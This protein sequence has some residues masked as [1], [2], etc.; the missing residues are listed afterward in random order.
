MGEGRRGGC[1]REE[2][3]GLLAGRWRIRWPVALAADQAADGAGRRAMR[4]GRE[5]GSPT[6]EEADAVAGAGGGGHTTREQERGDHQG[7]VGRGS[8]A[9]DTLW[10]GALARKEM[11]LP[12]GVAPTAVVARR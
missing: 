7:D 4:T 8:R 6:G 9:G 2:G 3:T 1:N 12:P 5:R 11:G 10:W